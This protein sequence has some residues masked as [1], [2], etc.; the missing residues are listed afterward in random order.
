[1]IPLASRGSLR[2]TLTDTLE[3][4]VIRFSGTVATTRVEKISNRFQS[5][6][7]NFLKIDVGSN[8]VQNLHY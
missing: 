4:S 8:Y 7:L 3:G 6:Q 2:V 1:M 5:S